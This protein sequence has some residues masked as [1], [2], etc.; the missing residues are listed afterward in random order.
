[1]SATSERRVVDLF[2][3]AGG[4]SL[5]AKQAGF[6]VAAAFDNDLKLTSSFPANFSGTRLITD[7]LSTVGGD[8]IRAAMEGRPGGIVGGPPCQGFSAIGKRLANDPRR[9]LV[10]HFFRIVRDANP[11]F[12]VME[13]VKGLAYKGSREVLEASTRLVEE[14]FFLYGPTVLNAADFGASTS[15]PRLFVIGIHKDFGE[16]LSDS[17]FRKLRQPASTVKDAISD[18]QGAVRCANRDGLDFWKITCKRRCSDYAKKLR[19]EDRCFSGNLATVHS[20]EVVERFRTVPQGKMDPV[21]RHPRLKWSGQAPT[22]RAGTGPENGS[23]QSVRPI[24]PDLPRVITVREAARLQGFPDNFRFHST[25]WHSFRMIG[26][27][28]SPIMAKAIF[29]VIGARL[30]GYHT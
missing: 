11:L 13:N 17:E 24:H 8:A 3:G 30:G 20:K 14:K 18:L 9:D 26:N 16:P 12:F 15:R 25:I 27:S 6:E 22:L 2:A 4:L 29:Q 21:G 5:G 23:F 10:G 1:M 7:D 19:S 28:V